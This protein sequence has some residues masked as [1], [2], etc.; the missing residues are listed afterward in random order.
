MYKLTSITKALLFIRRSHCYQDMCFELSLGKYF[1][2]FNLFTPSFLSLV[3]MYTCVRLWVCVYVEDHTCYIAERL[4]VSLK[5]DREVKKG[6]RSEIILS[7]DLLKGNLR[8]NRK[9]R[10]YLVQALFS[11]GFRVTKSHIGNMFRRQLWMW[12]LNSWVSQSCRW[13]LRPE[14]TA[15]REQ[16]ILGNRIKRWWEG[17]GLRLEED[18]H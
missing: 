17:Q 11:I 14:V 3:Y 6:E 5:R 10:D 7:A 13:G 8:T 18:C 1:G 16:W 9:S 12:G 15:K 4:V 2:Q